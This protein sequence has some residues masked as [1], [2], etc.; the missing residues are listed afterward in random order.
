MA[1]DACGNTTSIVQNIYIV[2]SSAPVFVSFPTS[3]DVACD[4]V[5]PVEESPIDY[6]D[7][8]S[9]VTVSWQ[10]QIIAGDCPSNYT[11]VR[12]CTLTDGCGNSTV[13][14][15]TLNVSDTQNPVLAGV[16][17]DVTIECG[18]SMPMANV[19][20]WDNCSAQPE[21]FVA[22][23]METIGCV[24]YLTRRWTALDE[25]GNLS[26]DVQ[27]VT[28]VDETAPTLSAYPQSIVLSCGQTAGAAPVLTANDG[29]TGSVPVV[30]TETPL[31][32]GA[33]GS[34]Q[35]TWCAT[36]CSGNEECHTQ[37]ITFQPQALPVGMNAQLEA[38]QTA[39]NRIALELIADESTR[40]NVDLLDLNG[41]R[42]DTW[43]SG[44]MTAGETLSISA[45]VD[46]LVS[47]IYF[48][49]FSNG[50]NVITKRLP[51]VRN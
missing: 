6:S 9:L 38:W 45:D 7:D 32:T 43:F 41:R 4:L 22:E 21:F 31:T 27:V 3:A 44:D 11:S 12:T 34:L 39:T 35:R 15:Y 33:C 50:K 37:L 46:F 18:E 30:F 5:V 28:I 51:I 42:I 47:G 10:E 26:Q 8:C 49:Q 14:S 48:V 2:D 25:C 1:S 17:R 13:A 36:D 29:C 20:V 16:P 19:T 40:W 24:T 23:V